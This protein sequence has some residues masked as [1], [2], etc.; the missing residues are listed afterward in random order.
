M[1][2]QGGMMGNNE[3]ASI[4]TSAFVIH[5]D[6]YETTTIPVGSFREVTL[7]NSFVEALDDFRHGRVVPMDQ[8]LNEEPP[9]FDGD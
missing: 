3:T 5:G 8:A 6:S 9:A 4:Q 7:P 1:G 2:Y